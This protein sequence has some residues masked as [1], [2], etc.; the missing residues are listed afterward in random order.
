MIR[1]V[2]YIV[3][4]IYF[5][6]YSMKAQ[7]AP[8]N[9]PTSPDVNK[10]QT[11]GQISTSPYSGLTNIS[12]PIYTINEGDFQFPISL[13]YNS[14]GLKVREEAS[15][16]GIGWSLGFPGLISRTINGID[17]FFGEYNSS[18]SVTERG[19]YFNARANDNTLVPDFTGFVTIPNLMKIGLDTR[20]MPNDYQLDD[21]LDPGSNQTKQNTDFQPDVF[22]YKLPDY[23]GKFIFK[24]NRQPILEKFHDNLKI[25]ILDSL[26]ILSIGTEHTV[27]LKI[28]DNKGNTYFFNDYERLIYQAASIISTDNAWYISK[29]ITSKGDLIKFTYENIET[30]PGYNLLDYHGMPINLYNDCANGTAACGNFPF[31]ESKVF[32]GLKFFKSK[33]IKKIEFSEGVVEFEYEQREDVYLE[34]RISL[35]NIKNRNEELVKSIKLNHNYFVTNYST[36]NTSLGDWQQNME[37]YANREIYLNKRLQ[38]ESL[39]FINFN[40]EII[41]SQI[42]EYFNENIPA[43]NSTAMDLWGYFNG[44]KN[45]QNLFPDFTITIPNAQTSRPHESIMSYTGENTT[46]H[47]SGANRDVNPLFTNTMLLK[48]I[49]YPTKGTTE[50]KYENNTYDPGESFKKDDNASKISFF[51]KKDDNSF[52]FAGGL[53]IKSIINNDMIGGNYQTEY[54]YHDS[55]NSQYSNGILIER[56]NIFDF[57]KKRIA[58]FE[59]DSQY[60][61]NGLNGLVLLRNLPQYDEDFIGYKYVTE[62]KYDSSKFSKKIYHYYV[63]GSWVYSYIYSLGKGFDVPKNLLTENENIFFKNTIKSNSFYLRPYD[64][65]NTNLWLY[66]DYSFDYK[67]HEVKSEINP[68]NGLL[69]SVELFDDNNSIISSESFQYNWLPIPIQYWGVIY[70]LTEQEGVS[71]TSNMW[72]YFRYHN[73]YYFSLYPLINDIAT[74]KG[75]CEAQYNI[76]Y[77]SIKSINIP[78]PTGIVVKNYLNKKALTTTVDNTYSI[79]TGRSYL[80]SSKTTF[81]DLSNQETTYHY[82]HEKNNQK[83]IDANMVGIPLET[84]TKKNGKTISKIE[85]RYDNPLNLLPSS[86]LSFDMQDNTA[87]TEVKYNLYDNKGNLLQY[88]LK[89]DANDNGTPT[90]IIWGYN[91]T[92]LIA[93]I[94]GAKL[95]DIPQGLITAIVNASDYG[96][97]SYSEAA[98]L[99]QL[100]AFRTGLPNYQ[101]STYTYKP[102]IGVTTITPPSGMREIYTYDSANRLQSV[103]DVDGKIMKE[104]KYNYKP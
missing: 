77:K 103:V 59:P 75:H 39:E 48:K 36:L 69:K 16:V 32:E 79:I 26:N 4:F 23:S 13:D 15:R 92:Q 35:I 85:T 68:N 65:R 9:Y 88:T 73:P 78:G 46:L 76:A 94:E 33:L 71:L 55:I 37:S 97:P 86:V 104:Y 1:I 18:V 80:L 25:E 100:D 90:A 8:N 87:T 2:K 53:R 57:R 52:R 38:L 84:E 54:K 70:G 12:I 63:E 66:R 22:S 28:I 27:N 58:I 91:Q 20:I 50:F 61:P 93:K 83:L 24:R 74:T 102:L 43:K 44:A 40:Q 49:I 64:Q 72:H 5:I 31:N 19:K 10:M 11:Y 95:S 62:M 29:I 82:A 60:D 3:V 47:I 67:P 21:Y 99:T 42:F 6:N 98:L 30:F 45:N 56:P 34:K 41:S 17:D 7:Y 89:P 51:Q 14:R 81:P 101:I 96:S